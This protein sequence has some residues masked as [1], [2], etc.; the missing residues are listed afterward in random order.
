MLGQKAQALVEFFAYQTLNGLMV[1]VPVRA[2]ILQLN[3]GN[4][5][6]C[7]LLTFYNVRM[8]FNC[9]SIGR[10]RSPA[11]REP[12]RRPSAPPVLMKFEKLEDAVL[13]KQ[14][15]RRQTCT[16]GCNAISCEYVRHTAFEHPVMEEYRY[17]QAGAM[18]MGGGP[19]LAKRLR[20]RRCSAGGCPVCP[21]CCGLSARSPA[22]MMQPAQSGRGAPNQHCVI[23]IRGL[24]PQMN[25]DRL[26]LTSPGPV[27]QRGQ[28]QIRS[29]A[30]RRFALV[31]MLD[32][33]NRLSQAVDFF[34]TETDRV[35][36][37]AKG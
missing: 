21:C 36:Q 33:F 22:L 29:P 7:L 25:C 5:T 37:H 32:A 19:P 1:N 13:T 28:N 11:C 12:A 15:E 26:F 4:L 14:P 30:G 18:M 6:T 20:C 31:Q 24:S 9:E 34:C 27:R 10:L 17:D 23:V 8:D 2:N 35:G 16:A 3:G